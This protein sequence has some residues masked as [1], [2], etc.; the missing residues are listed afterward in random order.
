[1]N[2]RH[3]TGDHHGQTAGR[4]TLLVRAMDEIVGTHT[5]SS[6]PLDPIDRTRLYCPRQVQSF[7][8]RHDGLICPRG[9]FA[10][11]VP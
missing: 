3:M 6:T 9:L 8:R 1:M 10:L 4:A 2:R 7:L 5:S 11:C